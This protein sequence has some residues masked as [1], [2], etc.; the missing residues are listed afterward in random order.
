MDED[1]RWVYDALWG[2]GSER[3]AVSAAAVLRDALR[4]RAVSRRPIM[5]TAPQ[6]AVLRTALSLRHAQE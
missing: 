3:G 1:A 5:L 2:L 6:S 4:L